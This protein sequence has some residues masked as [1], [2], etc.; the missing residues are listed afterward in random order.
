MCIFVTIL[1]RPVFC[2]VNLTAWLLFQVLHDNLLNESDYDPEWLLT[3]TPLLDTSMELLPDVPFTDVGDIKNE[4]GD[5]KVEVDDLK[6]F[7]DINLSEF[8]C[9]FCVPGT[10]FFH[11]EL[12]V[13]LGIKAALESRR[14]TNFK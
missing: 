8:C 5:V 12:P 7:T 2:I 14:S 6:D 13:F 10:L 4:I 11:L 9:H 1:C 3:N